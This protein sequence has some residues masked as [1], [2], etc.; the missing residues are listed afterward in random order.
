MD[1]KTVSAIA[2][3]SSVSFTFR[4]LWSYVLE[5]HKRESMK[6]MNKLYI[7]DMEQKEHK[8]AISVKQNDKIVIFFSLCRLSRN[9]IYKCRNAFWNEYANTKYKTIL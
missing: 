7:Q 1:I 4:H 9:S 6:L 2:G 3:H 8:Y 5:E